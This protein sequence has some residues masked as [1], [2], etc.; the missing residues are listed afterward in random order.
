MNK[1]IVIGLDGATWDLLMPLAKEGFLPNLAGLLKSGTY[2][3]L[4]ST[5]PPITGPAWASFATGKNP[6]KTGIFDFLLPKDSLE[7][8]AT[9]TSKDICGKTFYEILEK[10]DKRTIII[11]LPLSYPP[12]TGRPTITSIMTQGEQFIFPADLIEKIPAFEKYRLVPDFNLKVQ[13]RDEEYL[14]DIR[15]LEKDRFICAQKLFEWEW[16][17]FF[18]LFSGI[19]WLQHELYDKLISDSFSRTHVAFQLFRDIDNYLGWFLEHLSDEACLLLISDHGFKAYKGSF[20]VNQWLKDNNFLKSHHGSKRTA[21]YQHRLLE[22]MAKA[23]SNNINKRGSEKRISLILPGFLIR[24][25]RYLGFGKIYRILAKYIPIRVQTETVP[26]YTR[27]SAICTTTEL[28]GI[29]LNLTGKYRDGIVEPIDSVI[30]KE[31]IISGLRKLRD[32]VVGGD[33]FDRVIDREEVYSGERTKF[34][35]D[36]LI[37]PRNFWAVAGELSV[38][39]KGGSFKQSRFNMHSL[40]G[41]LL[42]YGPGIKKGHEIHKAKIYDIAS[43]ILHL[44]GTPIPKD[45]DGTVLKEIFER[46]S[47][48]A[49]RPIQYE[50][51]DE[52]EQIRRKVDELKRLRGI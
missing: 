42:A 50:R 7:D 28:S 49:D 51:T 45:M 41:I 26:D 33:A 24:N 8:L 30:I 21:P 38:G 22:G 15:E 16:D 35:P 34:A 43:T 36:I 10:N 31:E 4:E 12:R 39:N 3:E 9:I 2:G 17:F 44:L 52:R 48:L 46:N 19:D 13:G 5:I 27:T 37:L 14:Q 20:H 23:A 47:E 6:G 25:L 1:V 11:N 40:Y 29:Y 18:L 32:P